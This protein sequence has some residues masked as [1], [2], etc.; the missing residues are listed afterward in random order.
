MKAPDT[1]L[2]RYSHVIINFLINIESIKL[3]DYLR[4]VSIIMGFPGGSVV[5]YACNAGDVGSIPGSERSPR[6]GNDHPF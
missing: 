5:E 6:E 3:K 2:Y 4:I 1:L